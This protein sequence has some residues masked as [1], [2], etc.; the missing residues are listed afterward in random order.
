MY[1]LICTLSGSATDPLYFDV[2][3][4]PEI[5]FQEKWIRIWPNIEKFQFFL[6]FSV[7]DIII[8]TVFF[9]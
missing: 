2:D 3:P 8:E 1:F 6:F 7:K 9:L 4:D 5:H